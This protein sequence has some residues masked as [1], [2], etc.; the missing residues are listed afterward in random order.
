MTLD[1]LWIALWVE[2]CVAFLFAILA[3]TFLGLWLGERGRRKDLAWLV[4]KDRARA[5]DA[6]V[7]DSPDAEAQAIEIMTEE[8]KTRLT[9]DIMRRT[10]C[11]LKDAQRDVDQMLTQL[12]RGGHGW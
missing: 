8:E 3:F 11:S 12:Q 4:Q 7:K 9:D 5:R 2:V 6:V 1:R 10:G